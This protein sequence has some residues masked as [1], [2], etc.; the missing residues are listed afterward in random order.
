MSEPRRAGALT[1]WGNAYLLGSMSLDEAVHGVVGDDAVHRV[2]GVPGEPD[3]VSLTVALGRLRSEGVTALRLVLPEPGDPTGLPGPATANARAMAAGS[4][5]L[6]VGPRDG[7]SYLLV[8]S[9]APSASGVA[10]C[11][12]VLEVEHSV[13][14]HGLPTLSEADRA[15][16]E[17]LSDTTS[18]LTAL[19]VAGGRDDVA[20]RLARLERQLR[21]IDLP[22]SMPP[23]AQRMIAS[24]T[25][26]LGVLAVAAD[27]DGAAVTAGEARGRADAL[28]P[29]RIA[30]R[31]AL[32][33]SYSAGAEQSGGTAAG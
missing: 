2:V 22:A 26:L 10:V 13:A 32:C 31:R 24:A 6:T 4:G 28:R 14:P 30:A 18:T 16:A 25:R 11:W 9:S 15:L 29:L 1:A 33:A 12:D 7:A 27:S 19:D 23:R 20:G 3:P 8:A 5:V 21:S 17:A